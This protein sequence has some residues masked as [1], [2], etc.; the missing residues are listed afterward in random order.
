MLAIK[1]LRDVLH[2]TLSR[3]EVRN[4]FNAELIQKLKSTFLDIDPNIRAVVIRGEGNVFC[5]GGDLNW[6]REAAGQTQAQNEADALELAE[7]FQAIC[8]CRGVVIALVQG[9]A[10]GGGCGLTAAA[11]V[12]VAVEGTKFCFSEVKLGLIPATI[13]TFVIPKIGAGHARHL[14]TTAEVFES[15][16]ALRIGLVHKVA[17]TMEIAEEMIHKTVNSVLANGPNAVH[18]SKQVALAEPM[19][20]HLAAK[21]LAEAR[22]SE[23][24][25][26]GVA[27]FLEK[28]K[29]AFWSEVSE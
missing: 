6:M 26:E 27:A 10:F 5:A 13:S 8:S 1:R 22:A 12:A 20:L 21:K 3:P 29:P 15:D 16:H 17:D 2:V 23:E 4:A 19:D 7:L 11:D 14:F 24:G 18:I 25:T 28:R 9:A